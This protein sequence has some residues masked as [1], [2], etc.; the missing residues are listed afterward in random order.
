MKKG[1]KQKG[2]RV[3]CNDCKFKK[4]PTLFNKV[5]GAYGDPAECLNLIKTHRPLEITYE[6]ELCEIRNSKNNCKG[7]EPKPVQNKS[8]GIFEIMREYLSKIIFTYLNKKH[9]SRREE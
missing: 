1:L 2:K 5:S 6:S 9:K 3:Y 8:K 7:F 4:P